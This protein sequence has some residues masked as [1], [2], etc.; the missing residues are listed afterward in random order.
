MNPTVLDSMERYPAF[1]NQGMT[2][3]LDIAPTSTPMNEKRKLRYFFH[4]DEKDSV[5]QD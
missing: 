5:A 3:S 1:L 4:S 2:R